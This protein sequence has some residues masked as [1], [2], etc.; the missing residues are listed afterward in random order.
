M[1]RSE[2]QM[3]LASTRITAS[4]AAPISGSGFSSIRTCS[5]AWKVTTR[6]RPGTVQRPTRLDADAGHL[7]AAALAVGAGRLGDPRFKCQ[8]L[9]EVGGLAV[10]EGD[11]LALEQLDEDLDEAGVEL[12]AGDTAQLDDRVV[13]GHR[14]A[15]GGARRHHVVG[16]G[17]GDDPGRLGDVVAG[18]PAW[19]ALGVDPLVVGGGD[20]GDRGVA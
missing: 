13:A 10:L 15:V 12:F 7:E 17:D 14:R 5:G 16:V 11:V 8:L 2:S 9:L 18:E 4:S 6:I 3:P 1:W 19:V 20:L